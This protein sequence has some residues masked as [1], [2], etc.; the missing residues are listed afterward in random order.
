MISGGNKIKY[1]KIRMTQVLAFVLVFGTSI[2]HTS[3][4]DDSRPNTLTLE[5]LME[6]RQSIKETNETFKEEKITTAFNK[7]V[8]F[9]GKLFYRSPDKLVKH[10]TSPDE[11]RYEIIKNTVHIETYDSDD[12]ETENQIVNL[13]RIP[14][15]YAY[16]TALRGTLSGDIESVR[17]FFKIMF[18]STNPHWK[19]TLTP[20]SESINKLIKSLIISGENENVLRITINET[21]GDS[22]ITM[23]QP[24]NIPATQTH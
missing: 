9:E 15:L 21:S 1:I 18:S 3:Y 11:I 2:L 20:K 16:I 5:S 8:F 19:L 24:Q 17:E 7:S 22:T 23:I 14:I 12:D 10:Y 6:T 4:A 13:E